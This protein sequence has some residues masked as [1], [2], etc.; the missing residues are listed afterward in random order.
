MS[1]KVD[2]KDVPAAYRPVHELIREH[3]LNAPDSIALEQDGETMS[4]A[5]LDSVSDSI[6]FQLQDHGMAAES[7]VVVLGE[8]SLQ[9]VVAFLGILKAGGSYIPIDS[10]TP[11]DRI[12]FMV[13]DC[14]AVC[15]LAQ[16]QDLSVVADLSDITMFDI[17][18][19]LS[20][21]NHL[22]SRPVAEPVTGTRR[23]YVIYTSGSTG[24]PKGVEI[25]HHSLSNLVA[26]YRDRLKLTSSDRIP[27]TASIAFDM[28]VAQIWS[29]LSCGAAVYIPPEDLL[30]NAPGFVE[31]LVRRRIT[32]TDS[33]TRLGEMLFEEIWPKETALRTLLTGGAALRSR[34][35]QGLPFEVINGYG[36]TENTVD[37]TWSVVLPAEEAGDSLPPIGRPIANVQAYIVD[38]HFERVQSGESGELILGGENVARGYLNRPELTAER[39]VPDVF[40]SA[41]GARLYR[42]GDKVRMRSDGE[43]EFIGRMDDQVQLRGFRIE[44]GEIECAILKHP[45]VSAVTVCPLPDSVSVD[46]LA[47][48]VEGIA[49]ESLE[50]ELRENLAEILPEYMIPSTFTAVESMPYNLSGKIDR[51]ALPPPRR[52]SFESLSTAEA[53]D[54]LERDLTEIWRGLFG[55]IKLGVDDNFFD[56]GG[57]SLM[58]LRLISR[59]HRNLGKRITP[60]VLLRSPT[61][62]GLAQRLRGQSRDSLPACVVS[63]LDPG[64]KRPVFCVS[65]GGGGAHWFHPLLPH[66]DHERPFYVL[67]FLGLD[68]EM[69]ANASVPQIASVFAAAMKAVQ[70]EG[71]YLL[72]GFSLGGIFA[73]ETARQL[74]EQGDK[75]PLLFLL[76][77][78]G[79]GIH[80]S[81]WPKL[82]Q[83]IINF[84]ALSWR[85]KL[86]FFRDKYRWIAKNIKFKLASGETKEQ[87]TQYREVMQSHLDAINSYTPAVRDGILDIFRSER[88]P[89]SAP[90]DEYAGW[91]GYASEGICIHKIP[92]NHFSMFQPPNNR[93]FAEELEKC[94]GRAEG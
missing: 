4:Y 19:M 13:H 11:P 58:I 52:R 85:G 72:G 68:D 69:N 2:S 51:K 16:K 17:D 10:T 32:V 7:A 93:I 55:G 87:E 59:V 34:P 5:E 39:F 50:S 80:L 48:Y 57:T 70:P 8:R 25:E 24:T 64:D 61:I 56:L 3:A 1:E 84:I 63:M 23:A 30:V 71:P 92:G 77:Q 29:T 47:A 38:E 91:G 20:D 43:I 94:I 27:V 65:G 15:I 49:Q 81:F 22:A 76:D 21:M 28:T 79:P 26:F 9:T 31:W 40:S 12:A 83:Y 86:R 88:P 62:R 18:E 90:P 6:A 35:P 78:Y 53:A 33:P 41:A 44:L 66:I 14:E 60:A 67:D 36:P 46:E 45:A 54:D 42:T 89:R 82:R 37:S 74:Q 73:W 75:V